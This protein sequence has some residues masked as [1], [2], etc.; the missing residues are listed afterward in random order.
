MPKK[1]FP[2]SRLP[3]GSTGLLLQKPIGNGWTSGLN[4]TGRDSENWP[5]KRQTNGLNF[6]RVQ[7]C[8][9]KR[10]W[11][12][13]KRANSGRFNH[14]IRL[15]NQR[16]KDEKQRKRVSKTLATEESPLRRSENSNKRKNKQRNAF[17]FQEFFS[18]FIEINCN[19]TAKQMN[20]ES[21]LVREMVKIDLNST[22][23][24]RRG[25]QN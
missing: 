14:D 17:C 8:W 19:C 21:R 18:N 23:L 3:F 12:S 1:F 20:F 10:I 6:D 4:T 24:D 7:V 11:N 13:K 16:Y 5:E 15:P 2:V 22:Y 25:E 9:A